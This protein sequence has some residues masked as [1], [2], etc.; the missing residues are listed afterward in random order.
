MPIE[1]LD[2]GLKLLHGH[3][4]LNVPLLDVLDIL[5]ALLRIDVRGDG[6]GG[7]RQL[8]DVI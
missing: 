3:K 8:G 2:P 4:A 6:K 7:P 5:G 1:P